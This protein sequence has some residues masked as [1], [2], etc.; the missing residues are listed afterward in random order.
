MP[1]AKPLKDDLRKRTTDDLRDERDQLGGWIRQPAVRWLDPS[2][3]AKAGV[4]VAVSG[5][6]GK[7]AD[8]REIQTQPQGPLVPP[9][10]PAPGDSDP[11]DYSLSGELWID[12]LSDTGDGWPAT[13]TMAWLLAQPTLPFD[14]PAGAQPAIELPRGRIL[15]LGGDQVYPSA[16]PEAYEDRF[17]GPFAAALP[18]SDP[19]HAPDMYAT[20]GNHDWYD[21]LVSFLRLFCATSWIG[22]W[23]TRQRRSYFALKLPNRWWIWA[24]DIQLDTYIDDVQLQYFLDQKIG[25]GDKIILLTAK[26]SWIA[27]VDGRVEPPT[28]KFLNYFEERMVRDTGA[29]LVLTLT[30]DRHHY[31]RYEPEGGEGADEAPTRITAGG[32]GA[33]LSATHTLPE[34]LRL[35]TLARRLSAEHYVEQPEVVNRREEIYPSAAESRRLS[36]GILKLAALNPA[37]GRLLGAF[38]LLLGGGMLAALDAGSGGI[39][40]NAEGPFFLGFFERAAGGLS[41]TIAVLMLVGLLAGV[42]IKPNAFGKPP[43]W[44]AFVAR[45]ALAA[46]Q[47]AAHVVIAGAAIW[48]VIEIAS[49][50]PTFW[51]WVLGLGVSFATGA[52][53]GTTVFAAFMLFVHRV[54]KEKAQACSNQIFTGQSIP[55]YKNLLRI[56]LA[57]DG[58]LTI[59]PLGVDKACTEW[60]LADPKPRARFEPRGSKPQVHPIDVPLQFDA[61]GN[62]LV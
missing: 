36:A 24:I 57:P 14:T 11:F 25:A 44:L 58:T 46:L 30:G 13:Q 52:I 59:Y 42:D 9:A 10:V 43:R 18:Q 12:Y 32:G 6:F 2:I 56:R 47:T 53:L 3:L 16:T 55:D 45:L 50:A 29:R 62:R 48:L 21:G 35:K 8:K 40:K 28:W 34:K 61:K 31:A 54:R 27:A 60:E 39:V 1:A 15:L 33:Y 19:E 49:G 41:I 20:P 7:F 17:K 37:F 22:G 51:I 23:R 4:E 5:T 26:P 38:Y